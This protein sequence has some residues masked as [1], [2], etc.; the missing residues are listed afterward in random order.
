[1]ALLKTIE[2]DSGIVLR[3]HRI[4]SIHKITNVSTIIETASY[5]SKEKREQELKQLAN[6]E[7]VSLYIEGDFMSVDYDEA[8]TIK[9]WYEYLKTTEKYSDAED[10]EPTIN[11]DSSNT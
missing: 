4:V 1:M 2:M 7:M 6:K 3:Y 8:S 5:T 10:D 11:E 9:D